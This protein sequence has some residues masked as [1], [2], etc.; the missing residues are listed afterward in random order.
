MHKYKELILWQKARKLNTQVHRLI[1]NF[2]GGAPES[3]KDQMSRAA[4]SI[5][6]NIA[7]G[8]GRTSIKEFCRFL[9]IAQGSSYELETQLLLASDLH[10][11][12]EKRYRH[13]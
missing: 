5:P 7:E 1:S 3:F 8:S 9:S 6:S 13:F 4:I 11:T 2:P 12:S 10:Y